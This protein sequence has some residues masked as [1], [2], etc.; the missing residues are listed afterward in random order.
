MRRAATVV[1]VGWVGVVALA[2]NA[3]PVRGLDCSGNDFELRPLGA[4]TMEVALA[5]A[6][7]AGATE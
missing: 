4:T 1:L 3:R 7:V 5:W 2:G 6:P